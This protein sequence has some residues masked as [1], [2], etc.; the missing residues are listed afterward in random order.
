MAESLLT[1]DERR[2]NGGRISQSHLSIII[3]VRA[4]SRSSLSGVTAPRFR[5]RRRLYTLSEKTRGEAISTTRRYGDQRDGR[6]RNDTEVT[7]WKR[8]GNRRGERMDGRKSDGGG[9]EKKN[10]RITK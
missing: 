10:A 3:I 9:R 6:G 7:E 1:L 2:R 8:E 5:G 4:R